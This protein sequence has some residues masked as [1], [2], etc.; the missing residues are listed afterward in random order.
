M[1][2]R[3]GSKTNKT[4]R[5]DKREEHYAKM[6]RRTMETPAWRD[7]STTA[8][9]LY[10]WL[11]LEWHGPQWNNNGMVQLS[12]R[13]AAHRL[14]VSVNAA[15]RA[16]HDL[17]AKGFIVAREVACL[18]IDGSARSTSFEITEL[19]MRGTEG[20]SGRKLYVQ[21]SPGNDHPVRKPN[22]NNPEG[23]NGERTQNPVIEMMTPRH[24][25]EDDDQK[26]EI[27]EMKT[28][29]H[30]KDDVRADSVLRFVAK[31]VT[32]NSTKSVA[33]NGAP[34]LSARAGIELCPL[35]PARDEYIGGR[36]VGNPV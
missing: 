22:T 9:A 36:S 35:W 28:G 14:G 12:V 25:S 5:N 21:W 30:P 3:A 19:A 7:L 2:R 11:V 4:G 8:Q 1:S 23:R 34:I 29:R 33:A 16:F 32:S 26:E 17:Q 13:Q 10:P 18:G 31:S 27:I 24:R 20:I 6:H 15:A